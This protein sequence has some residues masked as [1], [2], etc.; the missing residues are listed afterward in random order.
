MLGDALM[1]CSCYAD[2]ISETFLF[3]PWDQEETSVNG[4]LNSTNEKSEMFL[5][6]NDSCLPFFPSREAHVRSFLPV[7]RSALMSRQVRPWLTLAL[8]GIAKDFDFCGT[9][10]FACPD[11]SCFDVLGSC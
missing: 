3:L 10:M 4:S 2:E 6:N 9:A 8:L 5:E 1:F 11:C 7:S